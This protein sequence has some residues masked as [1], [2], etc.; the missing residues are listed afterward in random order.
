MNIRNEVNNLPQ[1][2]TD[3]AGQV[4]QPVPA[5]PVTGQRTLREQVLGADKA[6]LSVAASQLAQTAMAP[7]SDVRLDKVASIQSAIQ[8]GTY[9]V[10]ASEV[11]KKLLQSLV[12]TEK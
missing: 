12:I 3:Q 11:A 7:G 6:Q 4:S 9:N 8:A 1:I 2:S 10:S 5:Q